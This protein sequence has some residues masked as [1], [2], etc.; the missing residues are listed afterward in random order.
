MKAGSGSFDLPDL[1]LSRDISF[2]FP[3]GHKNRRCA[4][5]ILI[6]DDHSLFRQGIKLLLNQIFDDLEV[7]D[8]GDA[9]LAFTS[10]QKEKNFDLILLDLAMPGMNKTQGL[11]RFVN[12]QPAVPVVILSAHVEPSEIM[13]CLQ[14]GARGYIPKAS[15]RDV[16]EHALALVLAGENFVP[17]NVLCSIREQRREE[18]EQGFDSLAP[19]NPLR[20]LTQRQRDTLA[21]IIEGQSNKEIARCLGLLES[22]VKA[23]VK[24]ILKKLSA[25]NRTQA[26]LIAR[27]LGWPRKTKTPLN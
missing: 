4:M 8:A 1:P 22:T 2:R 21:L 6:A 19:E 18:P 11:S 3:Q 15:S 26:A 14:A 13:A 17:N 9:D 5:K 10:L 20:S 24:V 27:D 23:H 16:L 12:W 25:Q 7:V